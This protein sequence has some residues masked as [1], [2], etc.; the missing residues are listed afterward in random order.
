MKLYPPWKGKKHKQSTIEKMRE[1]RKGRSPSLGKHW[2]IKDTSRMGN[3]R[4]NHWN[5]KGGISTLNTRIRNSIEYSKWRLAVFTRDDFTCQ[6]CRQVGGNLQVHHIEA[7]SNVI[8]DNN[9]RTF[10]DA[11]KCQKLWDANNG[12]TLCKECHEQTDTY[13]NNGDDSI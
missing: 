2:K 8:K 10:E 3:K 4:E 7:F 5:W 1:R 11:L 9:I 12:I 13:L 6:N